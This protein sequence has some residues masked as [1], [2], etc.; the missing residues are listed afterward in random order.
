MK[1]ETCVSCG[2]VIP[3]S[4]QYCPNCNAKCESKT[5]I[6]DLVKKALR[7]HKAF[8]LTNETLHLRDCQ[9]YCIQIDERSMGALCWV[10]ISDIISLCS[11]NGKSEEFC[12]E[13]L[14]LFGFEVTEYGILH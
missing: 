1:E 2:A 5:E 9:K 4:R 14:N 13:L 11:R 10:D 8:L 3:E 6:K 7:A 12:Y